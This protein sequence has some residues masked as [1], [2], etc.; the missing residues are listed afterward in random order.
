MIRGVREDDGQQCHV[1]GVSGRRQLIVYGVVQDHAQV[2]RVLGQ[3]FS[4]TQNRSNM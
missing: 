2:L 1:V 3:Q 4:E